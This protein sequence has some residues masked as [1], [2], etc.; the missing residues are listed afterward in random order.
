VVGFVPRAVITKDDIIGLMT[1]KA[2]RTFTVRDLPPSERPRERL[3][4]HGAESLAPVELL[5][6]IIGRGTAG[7]SVISLSGEL[8]ARFRGIRGIASASI[9]ELQN[10]AGVK[11]AKAAQIMAA[12]E[13]ARRLQEEQS[14][15]AGRPVIK[16]PEDVFNQVRSILA[17]KQK[18]HFIVLMLDTRN[19][20]NGIEVVS[21]GNLDTSLAHPREVF[22]KAVTSGAASVILV[23]NHPSGDPEPS[24][25]D[26]KLTKRMTEAGEIVGIA[27]TDHVIVCDNCYVSLK[28]RN[29]L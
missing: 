9:E 27:V 25:E 6:L 1:T 16:S 3:L 12:C 22:Q 5:S 10:V 19:H 26:I 21:V 28:G 24:E 23:H 17:G 18:E 4:Q 29:L 20:V 7:Q 2:G 8:L 15:V 14:D 13:L 11:L